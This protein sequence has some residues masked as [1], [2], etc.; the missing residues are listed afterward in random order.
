[1]TVHKA[2]GWTIKRV[3]LDLNFHSNHYSHMKF[4]AVF[5]ALSHVKCWD[6]IRL[7]LHS[8][9]GQ[10]FDPQAAYGYLV[11]LCPEH[12]ASAFFHGFAI[13]SSASVLADSRGA[14]WDQSLALSY[15]WE[16]DST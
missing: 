4:A 9:I 1:M 10:A 16:D 5:V 7:L 11:K 6:H 13:D 2:Q 8:R 3:V 15:A 14:T 12:E